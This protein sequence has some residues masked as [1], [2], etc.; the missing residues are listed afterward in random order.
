[1]KT[2]PPSKNWI[3]AAFIGAAVV[4]SSNGAVTDLRPTP[5]AMQP[6]GNP[7]DTTLNFGTWWHDAGTAVQDFDI[8]MHSSNNIPGSIHVVYDCQGAEGQD[9]AN[10]KSA[11]LAFGNFLQSLWGNNGWLGAG[12]TFDASKYESLTMDININTAVSSNTTIPIVL[13]GYNYENIALTNLPIT[14]A[15]WQHLVIPIPS[16]INL[17]NCTAYG[18]Y[19]WY[20][21]TAGTPP[22]HVEYWMDNVMVVAR[23]V[24]VPPPTLSLKP[25]TH[26]GLLFDSGPGEGGARGGVDTIINV[27]WAGVAANSPVTY[28][29]TVGWVP[30][31]AT[32]SNYEA[33]IFLAPSAGQG[34]PDWN[35]PDMGYLQVLNHSDG[36]ATARMMWKT[37]DAFDN[38]MLFNTAPG[39]DYGTNGY[40]AGTLG[41]LNAPTMLG[42]WSI[43]FTSD[44]DFVV[45]GPGGVST[46]LSLPAEWVASFNAL[47]GSAYAYFGGGPNG[48]ANA[49]QPMFLSNVSVSGGGYD[50]TNDFSVLPLDTATWGLLGNET[51]IIP[52]G[53]GWWP[54]WTLPA[55]NFNLQAAGDL[56]K[57][58]SWVV[59]TG[60]TNLPVP[61]TT[62]TSGNIGK[63]FVANANLPKKEHTYFV[64]QKLVVAKLQVLMPGE[65]NAPGTATG[66]IGTP[67]QQPLGAAVAVTVNAVDANWNIV[68]YCAD[69]VSLTSSDTAATD[70]MGAALPHAGQLTR[71]TA[72]FN[73][74]FGT[75]GSQTVTASDTSVTAVAANTG[76][77]TTITP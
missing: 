64:L 35:S 9:P 67:T 40:A 43:N 12:Q 28:S 27:Q 58:N 36:T 63:A 56:G 5:G 73:I 34:N 45:H 37:N 57:T 51:L 68:N 49:G 32:Y 59:L 29:M 19:D 20:N 2:K 47:G 72:T 3:A 33:H 54:S 61:V 76:S 55:A 22:A 16:T 71:G 1:M 53:G 77:S 18:V 62:Y 13:F 4:L 17:P 74:I 52:P 41:Y 24:P 46:N 66:K 75:S 10:I 42:T 30:D 31:P 39:G 15:G 23:G 69:N 8:S 14:T 11:N 38:T 70:E 44:T 25:M 48:N 6:G 21:T 50:L 60:N 7:D 26:S 65:T